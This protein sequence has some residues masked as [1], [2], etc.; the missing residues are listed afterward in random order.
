MSASA[1]QGGHKYAVEAA[2]MRYETLIAVLRLKGYATLQIQVV[3]KRT[4]VELTLV[5]VDVDSCEGMRSEAA[6]GRV[7]ARRCQ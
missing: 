4:L 1:T 5:D 3:T 7:V 2:C 6:S